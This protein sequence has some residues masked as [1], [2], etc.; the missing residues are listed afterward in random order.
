MNEFRST[1][2]I[3]YCSPAELKFLCSMHRVNA[4]GNPVEKDSLVEIKV[5]DI[6]DKI[7][8]EVEHVKKLEADMEKVQAD[9]MIME[10]VRDS[11]LNAIRKRIQTRQS[12]IDENKYILYVMDHTPSQELQRL[13]GKYN[14]I[15]LEKYYPQPFFPETFEQAIEEGCGQTLVHDEKSKWLTLAGKAA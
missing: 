1:V 3:K 6:Q 7:D 8:V 11:R 13:K 12:T 2:P 4:G 15:L 10:D 5:S 9:Q 14:N